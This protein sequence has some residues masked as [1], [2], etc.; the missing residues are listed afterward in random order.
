M[1]YYRKRLWASLYDLSPVTLAVR[2]VKILAASVLIL[3]LTA[4]WALSTLP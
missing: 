3:A 2:L 1:M 4:T